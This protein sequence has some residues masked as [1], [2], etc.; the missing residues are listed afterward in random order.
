MIFKDQS[1]LRKAWQTFK[2]QN[3]TFEKARGYKPNFGPTLDQIVKLWDELKK[4]EDDLT[5]AKRKLIVVGT[6]IE[7]ACK[8]ADT[9]LHEHER[10]V[11]TCPWTCPDF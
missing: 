8:I 7:S 9:I 10:V 3:P 6:K 11:K 2:S 4:A 1:E 5:A